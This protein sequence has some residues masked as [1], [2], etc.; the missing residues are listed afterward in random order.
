[1][2]NPTLEGHLTFALKHEGLDLAVLKRVFRAAGPHEIEVIVRVKPTESANIRALN[3]TGDFCRFFDATP[4]DD[5]PNETAFLRRYDTFRA[6]VNA[7]VDMP[8]GV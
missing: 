5:L 3:D 8:D 1:M 2:P 7:M 6:R 4:H